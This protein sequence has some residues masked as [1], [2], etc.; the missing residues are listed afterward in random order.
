MRIDEGLDTGPVFAQAKIPIDDKATGAELGDAIADLGAKLLAEVLPRL[1]QATPQPQTGEATYARKLTRLDALADWR[2]PA[3]CLGRT[4]RALAH[5]IPVHSFLGGARVQ[6]LAG[7]AIQ[8]E[9]KGRPGEILKANRKEILVACGEGALR[10]TSMRLNLGK[11][12]VLG[13]AE[14]LNGFAALFQAGAL[15]AEP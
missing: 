5:R 12:S 7:Q 9:A 8:T 11:G 4:I 10:L 1:P 13:P 6:L 14:A 3:P 2:R 15:F